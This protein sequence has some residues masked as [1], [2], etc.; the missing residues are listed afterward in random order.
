M[1]PSLCA[2]HYVLGRVSSD[3]LPRFAADWLNDGLDSPALRRLAGEESPIMS[4]VAPIFEKALKELGISIPKK[5][6]ALQLLARDYA[7]KIIQGSLTP[8]AGAG[9]ISWHVANQLEKA[10]PLLLSFVGA[11][12]ELDELEERTAEDGF[13]R[14]EY[15][16]ELETLILDS[17]RKL[18]NQS[19][20]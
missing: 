7:E 5:S 18:L 10:G 9:F 11:A 2:A 17:A 16:R 13:D 6:S 4:E 1:K 12:S 14:K 20:T 15:K 3:Q 8:H 19:Q